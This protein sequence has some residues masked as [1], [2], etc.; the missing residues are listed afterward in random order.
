MNRKAFP[1]IIKYEQ[2]VVDLTS[3]TV[4]IPIDNNISNYYQRTVI[5]I[6]SG[7]FADTLL[8]VRSSQGGVLTVD[9]VTGMTGSADIVIYQ[10]AKFPRAYDEARLSNR[11]R[12]FIPEFLK[13]AVTAQYEWVENGNATSL[14]EFKQIDYKVEQDRYSERFDTSMRNEAIDRLAPEARDLLEMNG[15]LANAIR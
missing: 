4:T 11:L 7:N 2:N 13:D 10:E 6:L 12:R 1:R 5:R 8:F 9:E 15:L 3:S 14:S